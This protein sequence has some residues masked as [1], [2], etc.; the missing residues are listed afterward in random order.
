MMIVGIPDGS[1]I[2]GSAV[3]LYS[4]PSISRPESRS[5]FQTYDCASTVSINDPMSSLCVPSP[6]YVTLKI[7]SF[8]SLRLMTDTILIGGAK[9]RSTVVFAWTTVMFM[10]DVVRAD[11]VKY[12]AEATEPS[13]CQPWRKQPAYR[14][15]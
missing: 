3:D 11:V 6:R 12:I 5:I 15:L 10:G 9:D 13:G 1:V 14:A 2:V 7:V 8:S 4:N